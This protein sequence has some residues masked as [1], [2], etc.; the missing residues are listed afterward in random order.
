MV[1][2]VKGRVENTYIEER[3]LEAYTSK[4]RQH[5]LEKEAGVPT[6]LNLSACSSIEGVT[7]YCLD[8]AET[9]IR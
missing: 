8:A 1:V 3:E 6:L 7:N 4:N 2:I 9:M 5:F